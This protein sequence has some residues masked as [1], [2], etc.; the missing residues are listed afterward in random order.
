[1]QFISEQT[2]NLPTEAAQETVSSHGKACV[3]SSKRECTALEFLL[4]G[5]SIAHVTS[6][7]AHV[8]HTFTVKGVEYISIATQIP[9]YNNFFL[10]SVK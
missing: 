4:L 6:T 9:V 2:M 7:V 5:F 1:M 8:L 10:K 3:H